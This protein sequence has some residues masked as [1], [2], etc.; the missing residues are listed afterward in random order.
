LRYFPWRASRKLDISLLLKVCPNC[1][2]DLVFRSDSSGDYYR[3]EQC[4][5]RAVQGL[6]ADR[7]TGIR[8]TAD[9]RPA[10]STPPALIPPGIGFS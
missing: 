9:Q 7:V 3:C 4:N 5:A 2:G 1:L 10:H 8:T 6:H